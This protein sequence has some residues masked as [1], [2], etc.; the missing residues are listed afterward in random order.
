MNIQLK[1]LTVAGVLFIG[2]ATAPSIYALESQGPQG[3]KMG[4]GMMGSGMMGGADMMDMMD[5][6]NEMMAT[7][8]KM[9]QGMMMDRD[10]ERPKIQSPTQGSTN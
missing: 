6:R 8:K 9:M 5:Q 4:E 2:L 3:S 1:P 7:C 10:F